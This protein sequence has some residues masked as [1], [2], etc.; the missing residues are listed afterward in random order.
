MAQDRKLEGRK[1]SQAPPPPTELSGRGSCL[2]SPASPLAFAY[3]YPTHFPE[4][5]RRAIEYERL[6]ASRIFREK[7]AG[8]TSSSQSSELLREWFWNVFLPAARGMCGLGKSGVW[9]LDQVKSNADD[10][11]VKAA[12]AA[13]IPEAELRA[14][15]EWIEYERLLSLVCAGACPEPTEG[16]LPKANATGMNRPARQEIERFANDALAVAR[17]RILA[18]SEEKLN[19]ILG[20]V[21]LT[22]NS[23]GYLPAH[24]K[25][26]EEQVREMILAWTDAHVEAFTS[27]GI[28][29]DAQAETD[30]KAF[31]QQIA[32]GTI[33]GIR[34]QLQ[35][36]SVRLHIAEE[37]QGMPWH[38][39]IERAMDAALNEGV[40]KLSRQRIQYKAS[41]RPSQRVEA[42]S[43]PAP[44]SEAEPAAIVV[45]R[46]AR[47]YDEMQRGA[48][49]SLTAIIS[50]FGTKAPQQ[51]PQTPG[52]T[53]GIEHSESGT[54]KKPVSKRTLNPPEL[55]EARAAKQ[56]EKEQAV[57]A[58][59]RSDWLDQ[60][61]IE[62]TWTADTEIAVNG[63]PTYNTIQRYR[64]GKESTRDRSVRLALATAFGCEVSAVP[65]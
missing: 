57:R 60:T 8:E 9:R 61:M 14:S 29:C 43:T 17:N 27:Y 1:K 51:H 18:D 64:S 45:G 37:G 13:Q 28:P 62:K 56:A 24:V 54:R 65:K 52:A 33:A 5:L 11:F 47:D 20:Q 15:E 26:G 35:L 59:A 19:H 36:R 30:L 22:G 53:V 12:R 44:D 48:A 23:G 32:A 3:H 34:G 6:E 46:L 41:D 4:S 10:L 21:R 58:K 40:L 49:E 39:Q 42:S 25:W 7:S 63:G 16:V 2:P 55:K 31:A 38:L 50:P